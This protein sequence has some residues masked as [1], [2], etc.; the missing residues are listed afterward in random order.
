MKRLFGFSLAATAAFAV[1]AMAAPEHIRVRGTVASISGDTLTVHTA[2]GED[3]PVM[4]GGDTHYLKVLK[5]SLEAIVPGSFIGTATKSVGSKL[6]ALEVVVFPPEMKGAGEGHYD[7]DKLPDTTKTGEAGGSMAAS[8]MTNGSVAAVG[9]PG[10]GG[11]QSTMTNGTVATAA[12]AHGTKRLRV[13]YKG[14]EQTILVPETAPIVT[15]SPAAMSD[16][17]QGAAVFVNGI[18]E[19]GGGKITAGAVAIGT[20]GVTPPM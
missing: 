18:K 19:G 16:V 5:S 12:A 7:W 11:V 4:L 15:F 10:S 13:T 6:V 20:E 9:A 1:A 8:T 17:T 3:V 2:T 14:G